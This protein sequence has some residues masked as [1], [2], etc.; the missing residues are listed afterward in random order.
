MDEYENINGIDDREE[1][2]IEEEQENVEDNVEENDDDII[3]DGSRHDN[4]NIF[5]VP[6]YEIK[7]SSPRSHSYEENEYSP[8]VDENEPST[9]EYNIYAVTSEIPIYQAI[10]LPTEE[11]RT[12]DDD[13]YTQTN[14]RSDDAV[15]CELNPHVQ[16]CDVQRC[17]GVNDCP[18]GED[19]ENC[20]GSVLVYY[21]LFY[22]IFIL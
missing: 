9:E 20:H 3:V 13:Q 22:F 14:C 6:D 10:P 15:R 12:G 8:H 7:E 19:E 11:S 16:I 5:D 4:N 2:K 21:F 18:D 17:D 1:E